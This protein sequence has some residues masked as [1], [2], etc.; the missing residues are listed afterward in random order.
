[1]V[2]WGRSGRE[3]KCT[4]EEGVI[5]IDRYENKSCLYE[6]WIEVTSITVMIGY[7]NTSV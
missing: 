4:P 2:F 1:M 7:V 6:N 3:H 5:D